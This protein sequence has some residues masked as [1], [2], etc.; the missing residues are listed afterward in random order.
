VFKSAALLGFGGSLA[1]E[2][3]VCCFA[4]RALGATRLIG[5]LTDLDLREGTGLDATEGR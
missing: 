3:C 5:G 1:Q 2:P 4:N